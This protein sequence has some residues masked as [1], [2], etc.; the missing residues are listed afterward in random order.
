M[1]VQRTNLISLFTIYIT[2]ITGVYSQF[3]GI[4]WRKLIR[5]TTSTIDTCPY[6]F[7]STIGGTSS[8]T[9]PL[10][11]NSV[12]LYSFPFINNSIIIKGTTALSNNGK[13][14]TGILYVGGEKQTQDGHIFTSPS[15][16]GIMSIKPSLFTDIQDNTA[17]HCS[18]TDEDISQLHNNHYIYDN[19]RNIYENPL[20]QRYGATRFMAPPTVPTNDNIPNYCSS[21]IGVIGGTLYNKIGRPHV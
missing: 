7:P 3:S 21:T 6:L 13:T 9:I 19:N 12:P 1:I 18:T 2:L 10:A 17:I 16:S 20:S 15:S 8:Y 11:N 4:T 5:K 14:S